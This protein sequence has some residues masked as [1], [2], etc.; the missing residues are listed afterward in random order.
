LGGIL[1]ASRTAA[2]MRLSVS[3][4]VLLIGLFFHGSTMP[5]LVT[6]CIFCGRTDLSR[7]H[8]WSTWMHQFIRKPN[9][10]QK[11]IRRVI[12]TSVKTGIKRETQA[13][14]RPGDIISMKLKVVCGNHC[15]AGWMSRIESRVKPIL[16]PLL[17][18]L[19]T[20]LPKYSQEILATWI[21]MKLM[22]AEFSMPPDDIV[23]PALERSLLMG[24]QRPPDDIMAIWIGRYQGN[25]W[26]NTYI[27]HGAAV[28]WAPA[29][30]VPVVTPENSRRRTV[31]AQTLFMGQLYIQAVTTTVPQIK[32]QTP[33]PF[34]YHIKQ[35]WP[36]KRELS[37]PPEIPM[38]DVVA[39]LLA[40][41]FDRFAARLPV[42]PGAPGE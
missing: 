14:V 9:K 17:L 21:A 7:E 18:G 22:V 41:G 10:P 31:Q 26:S 37:W 1:N 35:I 2:F 23:T 15:N 3:S 33:A 13:I 42:A 39:N 12:S 28:A 36:F 30:T 11:H 32:M 29:G 34:A 38:N 19:P 6:K 16:I 20:T 25:I 8:V 4:A 5:K 24:R 40:T 27:S